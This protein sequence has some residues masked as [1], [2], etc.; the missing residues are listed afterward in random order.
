MPMT[1][2]F[3]IEFT[4]PVRPVDQLVTYIIEKLRILCMAAIPEIKYI[5]LK[6]L[7]I[8]RVKKRYKQCEVQKADERKN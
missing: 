6:Y 2:V 3:T 5:Y 4:T 7:F 1:L 8:M